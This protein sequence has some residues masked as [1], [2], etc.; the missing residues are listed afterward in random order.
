MGR[1]A[2]RH[3]CV[4][5]SSGTFGGTNGTSDPWQGGSSSQQS[6]SEISVE[7]GRVSSKTEVIA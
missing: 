2:K 1:R 4:S 6:E 5:L 3:I 7:A